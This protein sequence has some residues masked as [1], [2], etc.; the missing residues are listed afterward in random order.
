MVDLNRLDAY[1]TNRA[2]GY[3][4]A[5]DAGASKFRYAWQHKKLLYFL[6]FHKSH[7]DVDTVRRFNQAALRVFARDGY[8]EGKLLPW[9]I[10]VAPFDKST[11]KKYN[12]IYE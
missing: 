8:L 6:V 4:R 9:N 2:V 3:Q 7:T 11:L 5:K 1:Y 10:S 12:I